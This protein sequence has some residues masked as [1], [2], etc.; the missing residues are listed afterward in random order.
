[1]VIKNK[2]FNWIIIGLCASLCFFGRFFYLLPNFHL[3][4]SATAVLF[5]FIGSIILWL[6][7]GID[8]PSI[9]CLFSLGFVKEIGFDGVFKSSFGNSTFVF[10]LFTFVCTYALSKTSLIKRIAISFI[11]NKLAKKSGYWFI[12]LFFLAVLFLGLFMSPS[13]LF[14]VM[15]PIVEEIFKITKTE[16]GN[17]VASILMIGLG[18]TVSIS[19]GMTPI[20]HVF[21]VLAL[22]AAKVTVTPIQYMGFAIPVGI[23]IFALMYG[24]LIC[25]ISKKEINKFTS[26]DV[27]SLKDN[28]DKVSI[29]DIL[30]LII[31]ISV[32]LLWV[33][34]SF[35]KDWNPEVYKAINQY[36]TAMPPVLGTILLCVI[37]IDNKPLVKIDDAFKNGIP[38]TA[39]VMC[40][41]T[42]ALSSALMNDSI[43]IKNYLENNIGKSISTL[44]AAVILIIFGI[45]AT[46]QTN[47][48]SNMVTAT[49]VASVAAS[50]IT[51]TSG[52]DMAVVASIVGMLAS[53]AFAT[54]PS[55]PHIAIVAG[56]EY[57]STIKVLVYGLIMMVVALI[58]VLGVGYPLGTLIM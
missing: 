5:I 36:G 20:A 22:S 12:L 45:W 57:C 41:A 16:K 8:W 39:L 29:K 7:I 46:L 38:W 27:S 24:I 32:I 18:F 56:S 48:S 58:I 28:L 25:A 37:R 6:T 14:V 47:V 3:G 42:L 49:L 9:L 51:P 40:A 21:P 30:V 11:D 50:V 43:G 17:K 10:L 54:P 53:F 23:I 31:F 4:E 52:L 35:F 13:V 19:S 2:I 44:P 55:M 1:M 15:L 33:V 26:V 34:P